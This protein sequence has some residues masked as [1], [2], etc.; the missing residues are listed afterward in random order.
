ML[1]GICH[2]VQFEFVLYFFLSQNCRRSSCSKLHSSSFFFPFS[3]LC[4]LQ[5]GQGAEQ[6]CS[7]NWATKQSQ[8]LLHF[9]W[10]S[11][12]FFL[13]LDFCLSTW[14]HTL[15]SLPLLRNLSALPSTWLFMLL[16]WPIT[17]DDWSHH[18]TN[19]FLLQFLSLPVIQWFN[20]FVGVTAFH[21]FPISICWYFRIQLTKEDLFT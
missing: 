10:V 13:V 7:V 15:S 17:N 16:P 9:L 5:W 4:N 6:A 19:C 11:F 12:F 8:M 18:Q 3:P 20:Y 2:S 14:W 1:F 21:S